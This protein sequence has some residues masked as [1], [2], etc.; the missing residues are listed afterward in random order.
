MRV[1]TN[2]SLPDLL[3][4]LRS[5]PGGEVTLE[6]PDNCPLLLTATEFRALTDTATQQGL[7][8]TLETEDRLRRQ[9]AA[10]FRLPVSGEPEAGTPTP[11]DGRR[12]S[13]PGGLSLGG[14]RRG[15]QAVQ[16][17]AAATGNGVAEEDPIAVSRRRRT[18]VY[19]PGFAGQERAP[20]ADP[21][22]EYDGAGALDYLDGEVAHRL[23]ARRWGS[24]VAIVG[25]V[26]LA[27]VI[28][29]WY[30]LP[31]ISVD[32]TL[33]QQ[34]VQTELIYT[35]AAPG[36]QIP[37]DA[38]FVVTAT[39]GEQEVRFTYA[40]PAT[41]VRRDPD[42]T[43]TG[44][45]ELRNPGEAAVTIASGAELGTIGGG[46][47]VTT[48]EIEVPAAR[49][50]AAGQAEVAVRA[51]EP[52][53]AGNLPQGYLTGKLQDQNVF[54]SNRAAAI[55]GGTDRETPLVS[56][57]DLA[58]IREEAEAKIAQIAADAWA[59]QLPEGQALVKLSVQA[60]S[61]EL[62]VEQEA[63]AETDTVTL[64]GTVQATGLLYSLA[65]VQAQARQPVEEQLM[66]QV[67]EG[68][69]LDA[70]SVILGEP[71]VI[72]PAP[73]IIQYEVTAAG[74]A[75]AIF[76]DEEQERLATSL[77]GLDPAEAEGAV[78]AAPAVAAVDMN[79]SPGWWFERMPRLESRIAIDVQQ[80]A[81]P[82]P[83]FVEGTPPATP[84]E[85]LGLRTEDLEPVI[86][87]SY[88]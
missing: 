11:S 65:D 50:G 60:T 70:D 10:M 82:L 15:Q 6:V 34:P 68:F 84:P 21:A 85:D 39:E 25:I 7:T 36:A 12:P 64:S 48:A 74:V 17:A 52:G 23:S 9:I 54:Y 53:T 38:S 42:Q 88:S 4:R 27:G 32:V 73:D 71:E 30:L 37:S 35:V 80:G 19:E 14:W 22:S 31:G 44:T 45:V 16:A 40:I 72:A 3:D 26:V 5:V 81:P 76:T 59:A 57:E 66:E 79:Y 51:A 29:S 46:A 8:L 47:Y 24:I 78:L 75:K 83:D 77:V 49:D 61:P 1:E 2:E 43:A 28:A 55:E 86:T 87:Q 69:A 63:G 33:E 58:T 18:G 67:P 20:K 56:E 62:N 13:S 41:G